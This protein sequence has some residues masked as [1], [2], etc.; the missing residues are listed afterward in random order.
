MTSATL[1]LAGLHSALLSLL[2]GWPLAVI[3]V[4][5]SEKIIL[6]NRAAEQ[7]FGWTAAETIDRSYTD[8][9]QK[10]GPPLRDHLKRVMAGESLANKEIRLQ[11]KPGR[12]LD[13]NWSAAPLRDSGG[14]PIGAL[15]LIE[16][17]TI[18]KQLEWAQVESERFSRAI[19]DA[20]PQHIAIIDET[21]TI[22]TVNKAWRE[23]AAANSEHPEKLCEGANYLAACEANEGEG[24]QEA[25]AYAQGILAV[26]N[27]TLIEFSLEYSCHSPEGQYWYNGR[28]TRFTGEGPLRLVITH[29]NITELKLAEKAIQQL[30]QY[31]TLTRLPNRMLLQDR[32][33]Q[34]LAKAKR[35]RLR[36]AVL[37]LDLDRFK[38][39]NDSLGHAAGDNLLKIVAARLNDCVRQSDTVARLGGDEF[40]IVLPTVPQTEDVTLIAKKVLQSL[41][42]PVDLE[43]QEVFTSTSIGI[44]LYPVDGKDVDS[45]IRCADMAMYRAKETGRNTYQFF[46]EE[47]N[48]Q[49]R[50]RLAMENGLRHALERRELQL[51]YQEQT[52]L[53]SGKITG[54]EVL[55]RWQHPELGILPPSVFIHLA[56]ETGLMLP[57]GEWVLRTACAQN[58]AWQESGLPPLRITVNISGRQLNHY[59]L[60]EN[61]ARILNETELSPQWLELEL[62]ENLI[63]N[64]IESTL[65]ILRALKRLGVSLA[66]DDF[67]TGFSSLKN[68]K[69]LPIDRLKIDHSFLQGLGNSAD[70]TAIIKTII[71]MAHNLGTR[72]IAEGVETNQQRDFLK[73]HGCDEVQGYYFSRPVP[74]DEF[75]KLLKTI[76]A[77]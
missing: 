68:L 37:F 70:S 40:I 42:C 43:G 24:V 10:S 66:I 13:A 12:Q 44:A 50:Q 16:N 77:I 53:A 29:D 21:G 36:A 74:H 34:V 56:E 8:F 60:V 5:Q 46:S 17:I 45:L 28:V 72:V 32:L 6:W 38:L 9:Q 23:F 41:A 47:M 1:T 49:M 64:D 7:I 59:R 3:G 27:G 69:R 48:Q 52:D 55:L 65:K 35:E 62:T 30:A 67:G 58:R 22:I 61:L 39:V 63:S 11:T 71:A 75:S 57:I 19:V 14:Q 31:D 51:H 15:I 26:M 25:E 2:D 20:L 73:D 33:G 54:V 76:G 18:R 4:D